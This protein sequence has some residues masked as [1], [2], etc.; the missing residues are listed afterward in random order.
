[1]ECPGELKPACT[2]GCNGNKIIT[3]SGLM[4]DFSD[5][6]PEQICIEDISWALSNL[7]RFTGHCEFYS[8]AQHS[9]LCYELSKMLFPWDP[10]LWFATF[11]H[12]TQEA[13]LTDISTPLKALLP[14]YKKLESVI[15]SIIAKK[16]NISTFH[17]ETVKYIDRAILKAEK[18]HLFPGSECWAELEEYPDYEVE[19]QPMGPGEA[20]EKFM[21]AYNDI[22]YILS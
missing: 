17:K 9:C 21:D 2:T 20:N 8:V 18:K 12:D 6:K 4:F 19:F 22:T 5:P 13:Y 16:F 1:M 3:R 10:E 7:C 14:E 15:E 11:T